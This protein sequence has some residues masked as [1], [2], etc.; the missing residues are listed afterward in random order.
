MRRKIGFSYEWTL[1]SF[2]LEILIILDYELN[3]E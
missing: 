3:I 1:F 2:F